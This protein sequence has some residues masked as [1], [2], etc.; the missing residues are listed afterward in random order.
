MHLCAQVTALKRRLGLPWGVLLELHGWWHILTSISS[1]TFMAMVEFLTSPEH[2]S[3][4]AGFAWPAKK[5]LGDLAQA[6]P[7]PI[8][9]VKAKMNGSASNG[10]IDKKTS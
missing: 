1:Y 2:E 6:V 8:S 10:S 3:R 4:G 7:T 5:V 9:L